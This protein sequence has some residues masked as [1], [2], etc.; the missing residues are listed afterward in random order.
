MMWILGNMSHASATDL[1]PP[2]P[3]PGRL[4]RYRVPRSVAFAGISASLLAIFV[5]AGAPAPLLTLYEGSWKFAPSVLTLVFGV[6]AVAL[7][8]ALLVIGSLSDHVGRR[9]LLIGALALELVAMIIFLSAG[10]VAWLLVGRVLQGIAT[11]V[12]SSTFGAAIVELAS[13]RQK[14]VAALMISLA[15][16]CGLAVGVLFSGLVALAIPSAAESTVWIIL[17]IVMTLGTLVA[18]A[19]PE[20][21]GRRPGA[22]RSLIPRVT[23]PPEVR[24]LFGRTVP[25]VISVFLETALFLGLIPTILAGG[26]GVRAPIVGGA[27]IFLMF[28]AASGVSGV[29]GDVRPHRLKVLGNAG[30]AAG[31]VLILLSLA[32]GVLP[33]IWLGAVVA[34]AG[35]GAAFTGTTRSLLPQVRPHERAGLLSAV[36]TIAYLTLGGSAIVAGYLADVVGVK[37]MAMGFSVALVVAS[38]FGLLLA[39]PAFSA[40]GDSK[41][42]GLLRDRGHRCGDRI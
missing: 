13:E 28:A 23:V 3:K 32:A 7:V 5:A 22:I 11:G 4:A 9:P 27:I 40:T 30:M 1:I 17:V 42:P 41:G 33:F 19:T 2:A 31:A 20:T 26:F 12:A 18:L 39:A 16:T 34:G 25:S 35:M 36:F 21:S 10:S 29:A 38:L 6:Y 8:A 37:D 14:K 24:G 15:T